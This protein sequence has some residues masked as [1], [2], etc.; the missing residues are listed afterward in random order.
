MVNMW[1]VKRVSR[2]VLTKEEQVGRTSSKKKEE[3]SESKQEGGCRG[4]ST[5]AV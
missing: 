4:K 5:E 3:A 1:R 2:E